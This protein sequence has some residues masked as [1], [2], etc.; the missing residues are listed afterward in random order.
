MHRAGWKQRSLGAALAL[1]VQAGFVLLVLLSPSHPTRQAN[2]PRE[3]I[4][5]FPPLAIPAPSTIDARGP[6]KKRITAPALIPVPPPVVAPPSTAPSLAPPSGMAGFGRSLFGCTPERYASLS[7]EERSHCPKPGEGLAHNNDQELITGPRSRAKDEAMW[8]E[9]WDE[10][11][12][13]PAACLP[14]GGPGT[15][16]QCLMQQGMAENH[17]AAAAWAKIA[18]DRAAAAKPNP[19]SLPDVRQRQTTK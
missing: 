19:P 18:A 11:H 1:A 8:Q 13:V 16:A 17:R 15:T 4:L 10:D 6:R 3:T 2:Q 5:I 12:W 7:P 14:G 9:K